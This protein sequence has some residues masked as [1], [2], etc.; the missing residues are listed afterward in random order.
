[1]VWGGRSSYRKTVCKEGNSTETLRDGTMQNAIPP[2]PLLHR[3]HWRRATGSQTLPLS[4]GAGL[5]CL[6]SHSVVTKSISGIIKAFALQFSFC[7]CIC[8]IMQRNPNPYSSLLFRTSH[9]K[10][11]FTEWLHASPGCERKYIFQIHF[12]DPNNCLNCLWDEKSE[13]RV[14]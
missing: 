13:I 4:T 3:S 8:H 1:M 5:S 10:M 6:K 9:G 12:T 14:F 11:A 7:H 2:P